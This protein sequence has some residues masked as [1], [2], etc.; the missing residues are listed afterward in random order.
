MFLKK[1]LNKSFEKILKNVLNKSLKKSFE[2]NLDA[3]KNGHS[4]KCDNKQLGS[5]LSSIFYKAF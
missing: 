4:K 1:V 3:S 5:I 2:E